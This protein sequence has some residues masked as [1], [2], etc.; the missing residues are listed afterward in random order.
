MSD[1]LKSLQ[2]I[3]RFSFSEITQN[4]ILF[5]TPNNYVQL[6]FEIVDGIISQTQMNQNQISIFPTR[7]LD[8]KVQKSTK[9]NKYLIFRNDNWNQREQSYFIS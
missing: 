8:I 4:D 1:Y 6:E 9:T 7:K 3:N 2:K 5:S